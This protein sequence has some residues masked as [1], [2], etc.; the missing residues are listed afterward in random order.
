[1]KF[2]TTHLHA[3]F[4]CLASMVA[5]KKLY[6]DAEMVFPGAQEKPVR[7]FL[8]RGDFHVNYRRLKGF[9]LEQARLM[10]V[11]DAS[12]RER[13]G[14]FSALADREDVKVHI[15]DHHPSGNIDIPHELAEVRDRGATVTIFTEIFRDRGIDITPSE[16]TL[17][18]LGLYEDTGSLTFSS[19]REEDFRAAAW[20]LQKGADLDIVKTSLTQ[21]MTAV[22]VDLLNAL[23]KSL[24]FYQTGAMAVAIA[25][26]TAERYVGDLSTIVHRL[27]DIENPAALF[28]LVRMADR[29]HF[30]ARSRVEGVDAGAVAQSLGGGGHPTAA[31]ATIKGLM[32]P[33]VM[34]K[35]KAAIDTATQG[36]IQV[37]DIMAEKVI[38]AGVE[39]TVDEA[40]A[41]MTRFDIGGMPVMKAGQVAGLITRQLV[42]KAIH[43]QMGQR[44]LEEFMLT[45]FAT[46]HPE[47]SVA[48]LEELIIGRG[49]K[50]APV[51]DSKT[52][53]MVGWITRG[54][55]LSSLYGDSLK[56]K[57]RLEGGGKRREPLVKNVSNMIKELLPRRQ[58]DILGQAARI[59][60]SMGYVVYVAG[61][62]ARDLLLRSPSTDLDIVTEGDGVALAAALAESLGGRS[63]SHEKFKTAVVVLP[64]GEK[65]DVATARIEYYPYPAALPVVE[66]GALRN[67]LFRRDFSINAMAVRLNGPRP[68]SLIDYFGGQADLKNQAIRVL[69]NLSFVEDPTRAFRAVRFESRFGFSMGKQTLSLL[70]N[71]VRHQ[72]FNRLSGE[73][74]ISEIVMI[75]KERRPAV[76]VGRLLDLGLLKFVHPGIRFDAQVEQVMARLEEMV[77]W[78]DL[79]FPSTPAR[80]WLLFMM[81]LMDTLDR[82]GLE[83]MR[84]AYQ[85]SRHVVEL[86]ARS[87]EMAR[88]A[89]YAIGQ[90]SSSEKSPPLSRAREAFRGAIVEALLFMAA[91][92]EA[93]G[94]RKLVTRYIFVERETQPLLKGGDLMEM[95]L[96]PS[97][98]LGRILEKVYKAQ[99]DGQVQGR[100]QAL[101]LARRLAEKNE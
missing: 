31:S 89:T 36:N 18:M 87:L 101:D 46:I 77:A 51:V 11:V 16:A 99:L 56:K 35:L 72:L 48:A 91:R 71:A 93:E 37:R 3:D 74:M 32:M 100:A 50:R 14:L 41:R 88:K 44:P 33:Q 38:S 40:R 34:E 97:R 30:I 86:A 83:S 15:Y 29:I 78:H 65:L 59:G 4:D 52:G 43:H 70:G 23:L 5:A 63:H 27:M 92:S 39:E 80:R 45:E 47:D 19:V 85:S 64:D 55:A 20:L 98:E 21:E 42:E 84:L 76:A 94:M 7:D 28:T 90:V 62:F 75:L 73:R 81:A 82:E 54:M 2:I 22:Q 68:G 61:G 57:G 13:I 69:H 79:S 67:D 60:D 24:E 8:E 9:P 12:T 1:M 25:H 96:K 10:V 95:G 58:Q 17:M 53:A 26:A 6:P 49:Q 66:H